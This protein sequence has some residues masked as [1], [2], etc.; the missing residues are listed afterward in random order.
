VLKPSEFTTRTALFGVHLLLEAG[1]APELCQV[2]VGGGEVGAALVA[3]GPDKIF[4]TGSARTGHKVAVE[5]A[6]RF[7]PVNLELGGSD[8][9]VV[10]ADADLT[11]AARGAVWARFNNGGQTCAAAKR[12][13]VERVVYQ[14]FLD[15]LVR[16]VGTLQLGPGGTPGSDLG[17]IIRE[18]QLGDLERQLSASIALGARVLTGGHRRPDIG[19]T[20]FEPTVLTDVPLNA[21][22][23]REEVFGP[24]LPV[25]A[26][27]NTEDAIRLAN[28]SSY[29]LSASIWT[30]DRARGEVLA[31]RIQAGAVLVND[32]TCQVGAVEAPH[33]GEKESG[34]GRTHGEFGL[35]DTCRPRFVSSD[36]LDRIRKPWW[37]HYTAESLNA[38]DAFL[39]FAFSPSL[40]DRLRAVPQVLRLL[41]N[42]WS[43]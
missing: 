5:A 37:F 29:G 17:P 8:P 6:A 1:L 19:P 38:R 20:F 40:W 43:V 36:L 13:I 34:L 21:P 7:I 12:V 42:R 39:R 14:P 23:W 11:R 27:E 33:G 9:F 31:R 26:A 24:I 18:S 15:Q 41:V 25:V 2:V 32:A 22:V 28:D 16:M 4:F 35:L 3:A 10:L 30:G